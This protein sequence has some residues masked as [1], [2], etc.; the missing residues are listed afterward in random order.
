MPKISFVI[1]VYNA[2]KTLRK[3]VESIIFG[4]EKDVELILVEDRSKDNSWNLCMQLAD[5][6]PQIICLQNES[7]RGVSYTRNQGLRAATGKYVLFVDSD[8][9]VSG[10]YAKAFMDTCQANPGK[11]VLCGYLFL[12]YISGT[13]RLY[14]IDRQD[15]PLRT[16]PKASFLDLADEILL[17]Q[18]WNK[19][20]V[21][22]TIRENQ[23][24]FDESINMGEDFQ[25]VIDYLNAAA[26]T[27][28]VII[29]N[30][31]S[32]PMLMDS[33]NTI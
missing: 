9:W 23:I 24:V 26:Y 8:D 16:I 4:E 7:N 21:L 14:G 31:K 13:R 29:T 1:P 22:Q 6:F 5:E 19:L 27:E 32:S 10:N 12:D 3:C 25:F 28:C 20:F 2:A 15:I 18:L 11:M 30:R 17:Q 33:S